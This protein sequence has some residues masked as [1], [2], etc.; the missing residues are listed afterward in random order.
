[1][2]WFSVSGFWFAADEIGHCG[3][4]VNCAGCAISSRGLRHS[5]PGSSFKDQVST[6]YCTV[7]ARCLPVD[8]DCAALPLRLQPKTE[9]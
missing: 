1:V 8:I 4:F 2:Q 6:S 7:L 3:Q 5:A 9:N